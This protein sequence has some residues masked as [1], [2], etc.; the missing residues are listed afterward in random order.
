MNNTL[1]LWQP[2]GIEHTVD[3][4]TV[5][6]RLCTCQLPIVEVVVINVVREPNL[7]RI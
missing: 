2:L 1:E 7:I 4:A 3:Y 6:E 5:T